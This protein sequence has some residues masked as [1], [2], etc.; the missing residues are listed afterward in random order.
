MAK[1]LLY[2]CGALQAAAAAIY[3]MMLNTNGPV[4]LLGY[5]TL[6]AGACSFVAGL[7][8][9][10]AGRSWPLLLNGLSLATLGLLYSFFV[11]R[12]P[13]SLAAIA[14]L[15]VLM[16]VSMGA[17]AFVVSRTTRQWI[18]RLAA[19]AAFGF[20]IPFLSL[21][22]RWI[23]LQPGSRLDLIWLAAYFG[24]AAICLPALAGRVMRPR[25]A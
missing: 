22:F 11:R 9:S 12:Y 19:A 2:L 23:T 7:W 15:V 1:K 21:A 16:T 24:F 17:L 3:L 18:F 10:P 13:V 8:K 14:L 6:A 5:L 4:T 25:P 20:A